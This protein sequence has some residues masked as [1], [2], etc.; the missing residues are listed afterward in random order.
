MMNCRVAGR[1]L[2]LGVR[3]DLPS[4]EQAAWDAH[5]ASCPDCA[6]AAR[7]F[8]CDLAAAIAAAR[9]AA[10]TR[11]HPGR[12]RDRSGAARRFRPRY[13]WA[14]PIAA[15]AVIAL[16]LLG[17]S[18]P[19][20]EGWTEVQTAFAGCLQPPVPVESWSPPAVAGVVAV[21]TRDE[22]GHLRFAEGFEGEDMAGWRRYP[23]AK[24]RLRELRRQAGG[25][26]LVA[27]CEGVSSRPERRRILRAA[28][29]RLAPS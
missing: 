14:V 4:A 20:D 27:V 9:T 24:Q 21:L 2:S 16:V 12:G 22:D 18:T 5:L 19:R 25:P 15:A 17:R 1:H 6:T 28:L 10:P 8:G 13:A 3:G 7:A 26:L 11:P 29:E 23:W